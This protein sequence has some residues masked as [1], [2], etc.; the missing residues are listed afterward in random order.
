MHNYLI[1]HWIL[2]LFGLFFHLSTS[3]AQPLYKFI[4]VA[5][6]EAFDFGFV[7]SN[8]YY[9]LKK[10]GTNSLFLSYNLQL[11][12]SLNCTVF[13]LSKKDHSDTNFL[14]LYLFTHELGSISSNDTA[15]NTPICLVQLDQRISQNKKLHIKNGG[16]YRLQVNNTPILAKHIVD[17][18]KVN[19]KLT[20][21]PTG[22]IIDFK[23]LKRKN[24]TSE[25]A[26]ELLEYWKQY[27][28]YN[29]LRIDENETFYSSISF[30]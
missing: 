1:K 23:V 9:L 21:S 27:A 10:N 18:G 19:F 12:D 20:I 29:P 5:N 6:N 22:D 17:K 28:K 24:T 15:W 7:R 16:T 11:S 13:T 30:I 4:N 25:Q 14:N 8:D 26:L 2:L 3:F